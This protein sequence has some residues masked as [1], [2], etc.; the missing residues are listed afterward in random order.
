MSAPTP[1]PT[2]RGPLAGVRVIDLSAY[3]AGPYGCTLLADQ[4][5]DV[6]KIEPPAGDNLRHYPS[7]LP[8]E[9]RAFVG[10][11]RSKRGAV[12]D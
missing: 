5:A 6:L 9:S 3:I 7:T 12:L 2:A 11:N 8:L 4:G 10:V 1:T